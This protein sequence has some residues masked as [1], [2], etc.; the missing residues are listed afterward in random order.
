M[1][2]I[3]RRDWP[4]LGRLNRDYIQRLAIERKDLDFKGRTVLIDVNNCTHIA[5]GEMMFW[6]ILGE[7]YPISFMYHA[8]STLSP[9]PLLPRR[10]FNG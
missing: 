9:A 7:N 2:D 3:A 8:F 6:H 5:S 10:R 1:L 4:Y